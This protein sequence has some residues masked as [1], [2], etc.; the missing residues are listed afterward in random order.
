MNTAAV[1]SLTKEPTN[2]VTQ[3]SKASAITLMAVICGLG[4]LGWATDAGSRWGLLA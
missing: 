2:A 4:S 3:Q 1:R